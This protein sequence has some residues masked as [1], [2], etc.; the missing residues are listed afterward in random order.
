MEQEYLNRLKTLEDEMKE[1]KAELNTLK[2]NKVNSNQPRQQVTAPISKIDPQEKPL[3]KYF[4]PEENK[5]LATVSAV[6]TSAPDE[7]KPEKS[8]EEVFF[9]VLPKIFM[10]ILVLGILWGLKLA[11]NYGFLSDSI[12][13]SGGY[14][15]A[16]ALGVA[17]YVLEQK[18]KVTNSVAIS[19][20]GGSFIIG[21]LT[22]A[23]GAILYDV[24]SLNLALII[25]F[26]FIAYGIAISYWKQNE[27]LTVFVAFTSLLLPYLLEYMDFDKTIIAAFVVVLIAALQIVIIKYKQQ[28][29][30][31]VATFFSL[32]ALSVILN[33]G[34]DQPSVIFYGIVAVLAIFYFSWW[35]ICCGAEKFKELHASFLF[36]FSML[37]LG[38][39]ML[40]TDFQFTTLPV[41]LTVVIVQAVFAYVLWQKKDR[42]AF[43][44]VVTAGLLSILNVVFAFKFSQSLE[45]LFTLVV[46]FAGL[47]L[48]IK[49][50]ASL[51]KLLYSFAFGVNALFMYFSILTDPFWS[52]PNFELILIII[53]FVVAYVYAKQPK[54]NLGRFE[55]LL[56]KLYFLDLVPV[57]IFLFSWWYIDKFDNYYPLFGMNQYGYSNGML[58]AVLFAV[59]AGIAIVL[60]KKWV[61]PI[62]PLF[63][64]ALF[65]LKSVAYHSNS[66]Y[67]TNLFYESSFVRLVY[68][69]M[70][71]AILL[72]IWKK[73]LI[74]KAYEKWLA[75]NMELFSIIATIW[76]LLIVFNTTDFLN[77]MDVVSQN[78]VVITNT[79]SLFIAAVVTM[80]FGK[81]YTMINLNLTGIALLILAFFKMI[82]FDL[83]NLDLLVRSVLFIV[84][85]G[86]GLLVSNRLTKK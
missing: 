24:L 72:D 29:A 45:Q 17:A 32:I 4:F 71:L 26:A 10:V 77:S 7:V 63:A 9:G 30:L 25:A 43:D 68:I 47:M 5:G 35:K 42:T 49:L 74:Y 15:L 54:E 44:V 36:G 8:F 14:L 48:G 86:I 3:T 22:T 33:N 38:V 37:T 69:G 1:I 28:A 78:I 70:T 34:Y 13:I 61:G 18:D 52:L 57:G 2:T 58:A 12:K 79:F 39:L 62:L 59:L 66:W 11:S 40:S 85:G 51:M 41:G 60:P 16:I 19:M 23:A 6:V 31:Y 84:I 64:L 55:Q 50:R 81:R 21:I 65:I 56:E 80:I 67:E 83:S 53:M 46:L 27:V 76:L 73:G 75:G 20:Y 82:F